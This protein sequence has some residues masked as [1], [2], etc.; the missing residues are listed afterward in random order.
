MIGKSGGEFALSGVGTG[1]GVVVPFFRSSLASFVVIAVVVVVGR[2]TEHSSSFSSGMGAP[3]RSAIFVWGSWQSLR[4]NWLMLATYSSLGP[5]CGR[6]C[7]ATF[8]NL[9]VG[10]CCCVVVMADDEATLVVSGPESRCLCVTSP[11]NHNLRC[12]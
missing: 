6:L 1:D 7:T 3:K 11:P 9:R 4:A 12:C 10:R 2:D 8:P 5:R